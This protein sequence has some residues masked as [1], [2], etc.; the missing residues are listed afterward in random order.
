MVKRK[1]WIAEIA[2]ACAVLVALVVYAHLHF[3]AWSP[4]GDQTTEDGH[5]ISFS[6]ETLTYDP[7][8]N[9]Y[10]YTAEW[11]FLRQDQGWD[12]YDVASVSMS[13]ADSYYIVTSSAKTF[14]NYGAQTCYVD[15]T[16]NATPTKAI[17]R[18]V[19]SKRS[20]TNHNVAYSVRDGAIPNVCT[21][22]ETGSITVYIAKKPEVS[23]TPRNKVRFS[24]NHNYKAKF[25]LVPLDLNGTWTAV[26]EGEMIG[27][28]TL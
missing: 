6:S 2:L 14:S 1:T 21:P 24:Y 8:S 7:D 13:N 25:P 27:A 23:G 22:A 11:K 9:T 16:A 18:G 17:Y 10:C 5:P 15:D 3:T 19:L 20:E 12:P 4:M 26:S 28:E